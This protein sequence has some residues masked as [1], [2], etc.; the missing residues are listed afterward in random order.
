MEQMGE[1]GEV[2]RHLPLTPVAFEI[3][4]AL[5]EGE[6]H[7]YAIMR[8]VEERTGGAMS[9]HPGTLYRALARLVDE[10]LLAELEAPEDVDERRR[11]Y[12][13]SVLGRRVA[14]AEAE[15]L[16]GQL[17]AARSRRLLERPGRA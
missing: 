15:R 10:G 1:Q 7:G 17:S 11:Y 2:G 5:A 4:L 6:H 13:L 9:L 14:V 3:L 12:R 8:D 16:E